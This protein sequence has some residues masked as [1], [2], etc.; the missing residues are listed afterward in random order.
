VIR[1]RT[2]S[3]APWEERYGYSRAVRVGDLVFVA[4]TSATGSDGTPVAAGDPHGQTLFI[5]R[6]IERALHDVGASLADVV[7]ARYFVTDIGDADPVGRAHAELL[8]GVRPAMTM[9]E[10]SGLMMTEHLVEIEVD[11]VVTAEEDGDE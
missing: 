7:R 2:S 11:A 9:A 4:G 3:G 5:L 1:Q 8:G 6:K 10:V